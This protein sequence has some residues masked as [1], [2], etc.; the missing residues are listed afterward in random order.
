MEAS[1]PSVPPRKR[2]RRIGF[3]VGWVLAL[4]AMIAY[5]ALPA[6]WKRAQRQQLVEGHDLVT[7]TSL[8]IA[9]DPINFGLVG[10][11]AELLCAFRA[12][13]WT[14]ADSITL[15]TSMKIVGSV[16]LHRLDPAAPVSP[17]LFDGR[18]EDI[19]FER[20]V[21]ISA[22]RRHHIRLWRVA[23]AS[24]D[25]RP[26]WLASASF[27]RGVELSRYTLQVTHR[28][29]PDLDAERDFVGQSLGDAGAIRPFFQ[30][31][32]IGPTLHGRNGGGDPYFTDGEILIG[33]LARDCDLT[34]GRAVAPPRNP[35]QIDIRSA[36]IHALGEKH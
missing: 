28:I 18:A 31:E 24:Y 22:A 15:R 4:W 16:A 32:G 11:Q 33:V 1:S 20:P 8:G 7:R 9:G 25:D 27:D 26:L 21:G 19:A 2:L 12:A 17:L 13:G 34:P 29:G 35:P 30:I 3:L 6:I 10:D 36:I 14:L 23:G 5:L